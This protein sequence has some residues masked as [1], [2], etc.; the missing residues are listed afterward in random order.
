[1]A[2][3][4]EGTMPSLLQGV[5][6]QI[7]RERQPGQLGALKNMLSD[8][9][10]GLRRRPPARSVSL[11]SMVA[12]ADDFLFRAYIERGT[13]GRHLLINTE[14][15]AWQ[16]LSK[17]TGTVVNSGTST[18]L[19]T[20]IGA[21]SIQTASING[22]TYILNTEKQPVTTVSNTGKLNPTTTGFFRIN[23]SVF[24]KRWEGLRVS[25]ILNLPDSD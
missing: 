10:T 5:S 25:P 2:S 11:T 15:G 21:T 18:Y 8:P 9:V 22:L 4:Y 24:G 1:V 14:S 6:Q 23:T 7:P 17:D 19:Q 3:T 12:P 13:D 16:L 20:T